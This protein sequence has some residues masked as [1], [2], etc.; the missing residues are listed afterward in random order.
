MSALRNFHVPLPP[1]VYDQLRQEAERTNQTATSIVRQAIEYWLKQQKKA[2]ERR[3][4]AEYVE[5]MAGTAY[6]LD[7]DLEAAGIEFMLSQGQQ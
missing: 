3:Q 1:N 2:E 7:P 5:A 6:D 4:L